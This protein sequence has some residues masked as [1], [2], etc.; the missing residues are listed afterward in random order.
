MHDFAEREAGAGALSAGRGAPSGEAGRRI[1]VTLIGLA[2]LG[3]CVPASIGMVSAWRRSQFFGHAFAIPAFSVMLCWGRRHAILRLLQAP[4]PPAGGAVCVLLAGSFEMLAIIAD[5]RF[6][7]GVGI[8]ILLAATA[9]AIAGRA[10]LRLLALPLAFLLLMV[11][12]PGGISY[13]LLVS[14]KIL[15]T[16]MAVEVLRG[17]GVSVLSEGNRILIPG[18]TLFVADACSGLTS[19]VTMF[20]IACILAYSL[21][22]RLLSRLLLLAWVIPVAMFFNT[23]RVVATVLLVSRFGESFAQGLLHDGFGLSSSIAGT[24]S[25]IM[26]AKAL[27]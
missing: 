5:M 15:I 14:L 7:A 18:H 26:I 27:K 2:A 8:P 6:L 1:L 11:P 12:P 13:G 23:A 3:L 10:L 25:L 16:T 24:I 17:L 22:T 19:I 20:P 21:L 9:Y 4:Q